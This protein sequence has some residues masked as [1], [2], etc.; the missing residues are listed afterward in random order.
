MW[1]PSKSLNWYG[2]DVLKSVS[3]GL[4]LYKKQFLRCIVLCD[5][6]DTATDYHSLKFYYYCFMYQR[7]RFVWIPLNEELSGPC[8]VYFYF[9]LLNGR[10]EFVAIFRSDMHHM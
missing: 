7:V 9:S 1:S 4:L 10:T 8:P 3:A 6:G 2:A 5:P